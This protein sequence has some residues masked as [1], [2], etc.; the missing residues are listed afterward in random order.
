MKQ[1]LRLHFRVVVLMLIVV[2]SMTGCILS[3]AGKAMPRKEAS[4]PI[5]EATEL[6]IH[7]KTLPLD[8]VGIT[9]TPHTFSDDLKYWTPWFRWKPARKLGALVRIVVAHRGDPATPIELGMAFNG[10]GGLEWVEDGKWS[11]CDTP[12]TRSEGAKTPYALAPGKVDV[13][14]F[15]GNTPDWGLHREIKLTLMDRAA[16]VSEDVT[17]RLTRT[18]NRL[19]SITCLSEKDDGVAPDTLYVHI[20][21]VSDIA[22]TVKEI[23]LFAPVNGQGMDM[24]MPLTQFESWPTGAA[25]PEEDRCIIKAAAPAKLPL[26]RGLVQ[27]IIDRGE[28]PA[29]TLWT[30][31]MFKRD[32]FDIGCG[33]MDIPAG[34]GQ[35]PL[36]KESVLKL[37]KKM[38]VNVVHNENVPGYTDAT[39]ADGLYTKYPMRMMGEFADVAKYNAA[40][41]LPKIHGVDAVGE[42]QIGKMAPMEVYRKLRA[43]DA[44]Q[45]PTT[46]TM[47]DDR[48]FRY[49]AGLSDFQHFDSYRVSAPSCD[50]WYLYGDRWKGGRVSWGAPLEGIGE[51]TRTLRALNRPAPIAAWSQNAHEGWQD[52]ISRKR[53]S[54]TPD[55]ILIQAH[56]ALGNGITSL[57]WYSLQSWSPLRY[58]DTLGVTTRI[59]R[60]I[61]AL[62]PYFLT[63]DA[64]RHDRTF[65]QSEV[66]I[67]LSSI[68]TPK[69]ALLFVTDLTYQPNRKDR[70]FEFRGAREF[71][72]SFAL[73]GYLKNPVDVFRVD[74]T[75]VGEVSWSASRKGVFFTGT[76]DRA[77]IFVAAMD[78]DQR[79]AIA[80]KL[81]ALRA[82]EDALAFD[83]GEFDSDF[84]ELAKDLGYT[85]FEELA[86]KR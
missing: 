63:G 1:M 6:P 86:K 2:L 28:D 15:N 19:M 17:L 67:D 41:W 9:V 21:N 26:V 81:T 5:A 22:G 77:A 16:K 60:L 38:H 20:S 75:G 76:L 69:A 45:Y 54:P 72:A 73:P 79:A 4:E 30:P 18:N 34:N 58:R 23:R 14:T 51:M 25:V 59:G 42:P 31:L 35:I 61:R 13:F 8:I 12:E 74:S 53:R 82:E 27:V 57:Y 84:E 36:T 40:E 55:E 47:A 70:V 66:D 62:E 33:W 46:L 71:E 44:A 68:V 29:E 11:W 3:M 64:Y 32:R 43:Y 49:Y 37:L 10:R 50:A 83:P 24:I 48:G 78:K 39:A 56:Q 65:Y 52:Q 85:S 7:C 80:Q